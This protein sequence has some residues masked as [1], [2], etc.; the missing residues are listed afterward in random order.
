[1][2]LYAFLVPMPLWKTEQEEKMRT[3]KVETK[4]I[5]VFD[6]CRQEERNLSCHHLD[7]SRAL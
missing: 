1:M 7:A 5:V 6:K 2:R 3:N 4:E